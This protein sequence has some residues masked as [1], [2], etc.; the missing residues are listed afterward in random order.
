MS[1]RS[2]LLTIIKYTGGLSTALA[3]AGTAAIALFG[4]AIFAKLDAFSLGLNSSGASALNLSAHITNL[5]GAEIDLS[6]AQEREREAQDSLNAARLSG[7]GILEAESVAEKAA[8][9]VATATAAKTKASAAALASALTIAMLVLT[10]FSSID[11]TIRRA[12]ENSAEAERKAREEQDAAIAKANERIE[13]QKQEVQ[14]MEDVAASV[15]ELRKVLNSSTST[16]EE[17]REAQAKLLQIQNSLVESNNA[18]ADSLDLTNGNLKEQLGLIEQLTTEQLKQ[19]AQEWLDSTESERAIANSRL[20]S[21]STTSTDYLLSHKG[22][23]HSFDYRSILNSAISGAGVG[24][25]ASVNEDNTFTAWDNYGKRIGEGF[26]NGFWEGLGELT[27]LP[28]MFSHA[29]WVGES[30]A[31]FSFSGTV[32]EQLAAIK[33]LRD[34]IAKHY[35]ELGL[36]DEQNIAFT[37]ELDNQYAALNDDAYK[38]AQRTREIEQATYDWLNGTITEAE[39]L[40]K[41]YGITKKISDETGEWHNNIAKVTDEYD[42]LIDKLEELRDKDKEILDLEKAKRELENAQ[43]EATV[44]RFNEATGQWEWQVDEKRVAEARE[45]LEEQDYE[46][47]I[48]LLNKEDPPTNEQLVDLLDGLEEYLG[49]GFVDKIKQAFKDETNVDLDK[50]VNSYDSGGIAS[51]MGY[52]PKATDRPESVN[53]PDLTAKILSPVSNAHFDRYVRDMGLLFETARRY[54]QAPVVERVGGATDNRVDNS[55]QIIMNGVTIGADRRSSSLDETL[56]I[57]GIVPNE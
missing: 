38:Q 3:A 55:G 26:S 17:K 9:D 16:E 35:D 8:G 31:G 20:N 41:V 29:T 18:Y 4:P 6:F 13:A 46:A 25:I 21:T 15:E 37:T 54:A 57:A 40:E 19:K 30:K 11:S 27:G 2:N 22:W 34:Y 44:R 36:T 42:K 24:D 47:I 50:P 23:V 5:M 12:I 51:G 56:A 45:N 39:Y 28:T 48:D 14:S 33:L 7:I 32:E 49:T 53:N 1:V 43:N 52:M 10:V